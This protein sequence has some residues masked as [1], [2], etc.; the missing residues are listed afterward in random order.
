MNTKEKYINTNMIADWFDFASSKIEQRRDK[1]KKTRIFSTLTL[2]L[3]IQAGK[4]TIFVENSLS[5]NYL[6]SSHCKSRPSEL[7]AD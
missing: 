1:H 3:P 4:T 7:T 5:S 6:V 2:S